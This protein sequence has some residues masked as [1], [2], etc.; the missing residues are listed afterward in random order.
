MVI[1]PSPVLSL[2]FGMIQLKS[3]VKQK[4]RHDASLKAVYMTACKETK[5]VV[6]KAKNDA[7]KHI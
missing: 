4:M 7:T 2:K 3:S 6:A 1:I 5:R